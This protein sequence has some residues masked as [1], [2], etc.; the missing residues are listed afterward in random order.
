[1]KFCSESFKFRDWYSSLRLVR[2]PNRGI[3][4]QN[5]NLDWQRLCIPLDRLV[6]IV[7]PLTTMPESPTKLR[8]RQLSE[9]LT[10]LQGQVVEERHVNCSHH[11]RVLQSVS[12][13][14]PFIVNNH[15]ATGE[16]LESREGH[17]KDGQAAGAQPRVGEHKMQ[18][19]S[20]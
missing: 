11:H 6:E 5:S 7:M 10:T 1:M 15:R 19:G 13:H 12:I 20:L 4:I 2:S 3:K 17:H 18:C 16:E 14:Y 9:K 8:I